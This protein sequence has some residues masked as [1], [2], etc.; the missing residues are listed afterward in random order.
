MPSFKK[1]EKKIEGA[2]RGQSLYGKYMGFSGQICHPLFFGML[3][4]NSQCGFFTIGVLF[5]F[6]FYNNSERKIE[7]P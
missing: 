4:V 1:I 3:A 7:I 6:F 2:T 5:F